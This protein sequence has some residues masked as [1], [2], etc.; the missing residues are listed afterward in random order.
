[1]GVRLEDISLEW[2]LDNGRGTTAP[3]TRA[4]LY[5]QALRDFDLDVDALTAEK[6]AARARASNIRE[7]LAAALDF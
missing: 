7:Q 1:M 3:A 6:A 4:L 5:A 2:G